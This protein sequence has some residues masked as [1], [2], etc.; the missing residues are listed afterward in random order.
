VTVR[1]SRRTT[2]VE[3]LPPSTVSG[4]GGAVVKTNGEET[5]KKSPLVEMIVAGLIMLAGTGTLLMSVV[6]G[7]EVGTIV[8]SSCMGVGLLMMIIGVCWYLSK[9]QDTHDMDRRLDVRVIDA[10]LLADLIKRGVQVRE[11]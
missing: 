3:V 11:V 7:G 9:T 4:P 2:I 10:M 5:E 8:G 6:V 1:D